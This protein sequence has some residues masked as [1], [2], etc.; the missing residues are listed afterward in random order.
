MVSGQVVEGADVLN[1]L[2]QAV[3]VADAG[4][5]VTFANDAA[6]ATYSHW[7]P[8]PGTPIG[9][10]LAGL[11]PTEMAHHGLSEAMAGST[12]QGELFERVDGGALRQLGLSVTPMFTG[13][14]VSGLVVICEQLSAVR[15]AEAA[16]A[17]SERRMR[18]A[19]DAAELGSWQWD[20]VTG[21][22]VWDERLESIF[23]LPPGGYDQTFETWL[24]SIHPDDRETTMKIVNDA[25]EARSSYHLNVRV[26]W[27]DESV[28]WIEALG[29]VTTDSADNPTGTI[30]CVWDTTSKRAA[31]A[32][33]AAAFEAERQAWTL[34]EKMTIEREQLVTRVSEIADHLQTS[35]AASPIPEVDGA[36]IAVHYAPGGDELEHVGG[37]WYDA[38][39]TPNDTVAV[40]V[41]DVMGRGVAAATTMI[42]VRAGIRGLL[43]VD[44]SPEVLLTHADV[45]LDRD[46]PEQFVT[47]VAMLVDPRARTLT[48]SNAGHV[49]VVVVAPDGSAR[50]VGSTGLPLG[51]P[52]R[53]MRT[54]D[55]V[56]LESGSVV[57]MVTDGVVEGRGFDVDEGIARLTT[58][59]QQFAQAPLD[60][61]VGQI[62]T[63]A[64]RSLRDDVTVVAVRVG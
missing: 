50:Q 52:E 3:L 26:V 2:G 22:V 37:D 61:L 63:L 15:Q 62:A 27:P 11:E 12:W 16:A 4:G 28:H 48:V 43:T 59:A 56:A 46:A 31:E 53:R 13:E 17:E 32:E 1:A 36:S 40:V 19:Y 47:A 60:V 10:L 44:P 38:V 7:G 25:I 9:E 33:L 51:L 35:L 6:A 18:L 24:G 30:G 8:L 54:A 49:P 39:R 64:D 42:R 57:L 41:G 14:H 58:Q 23:G 5:V 45:M 55:K 20:M 34:A 21:L 29:R